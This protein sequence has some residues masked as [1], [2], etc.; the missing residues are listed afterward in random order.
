MVI[1]LWTEWD[2]FRLDW[3][4]VRVMHGYGK[5]CRRR[6]K[7]SVSVSVR[8]ELGQRSTESRSEGP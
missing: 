2:R 7:L 4:M 5:G 1:V 6:V 8:V 3:F